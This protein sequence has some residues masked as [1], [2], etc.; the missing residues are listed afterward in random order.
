MQA[1]SSSSA[2]DSHAGHAFLHDFC[3]AIPYGALALVAAAVLLSIGA[4]QAATSLAVGGV[5]VGGASVLS[6]KNWKVQ[7]SCTPMTLVSGG[8]HAT[9]WH[10]GATRGVSM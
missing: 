6:L 9:A 8:E 4:K 2:A 10:Q 5:V 1:S 7:A 3:M